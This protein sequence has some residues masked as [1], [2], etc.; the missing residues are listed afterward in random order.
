MNL[1]PLILLPPD[2]VGN[3]IRQ[4][5]FNFIIETCFREREPL[6]SSHFS[7]LLERIVLLRQ[8]S[9]RIGRCPTNHLA[10]L[11]WYEVI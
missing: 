3:S 9:I 6:S 1:S 7:N 2:R 11:F 5:T 10:R 4:R 8:E